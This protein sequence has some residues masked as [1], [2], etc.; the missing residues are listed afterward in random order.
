MLPTLIQR[1]DKKIISFLIQ[2]KNERL[3]EILKA[4]RCHILWVYS[5]Y[6]SIYETFLGYKLSIFEEY[7]ALNVCGYSAKRE[8]SKMKIF[9]FLFKERLLVFLVNESL[10]KLR[11]LISQSAFCLNL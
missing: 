6:I 11:P 5:Y 7:G 8:L 4:V 9:V 3:T 1:Y 2:F 10:L